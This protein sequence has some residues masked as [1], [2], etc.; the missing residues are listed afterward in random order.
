[1]LALPSL[2]PLIESFGAVHKPVN[3]WSAT[4]SQFCGSRRQAY[5]TL[6]LQ[7][8]TPSITANDWQEYSSGVQQQQQQAN[9]DSETP[10]GSLIKDLCDNMCTHLSFE[11]S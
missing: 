4:I 7:E 1:M 6:P 2:R 10:T 5:V 11:V 3:V 8:L 9:G